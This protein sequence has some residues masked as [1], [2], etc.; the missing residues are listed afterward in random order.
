MTS[1]SGCVEDTK[2]SAAR[3][4]RRATLAGLAALGTGIALPLT[5]SAAQ[6]AAKPRRI[7]VH[8]HTFSPDY[9]AARR[10]DRSMTPQIAD[11]MAPARTLEDMDQAGVTMSILSVP[12]A[13]K[14]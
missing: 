9:V 13:P 12:S 8:R 6:A 3:P 5:G 4:S 7:D 1:D 14:K 2:A 10:A 11:G